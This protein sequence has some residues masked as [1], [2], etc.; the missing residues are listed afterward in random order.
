MWTIGYKA[1]GAF[2]G[3]ILASQGVITVMADY[4]NF[5]PGRVQH[6]LEDVDLALGWVHNNIHAYGGDPE[7]IHLMGTA[8]RDEQMTARA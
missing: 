7:N 1:W 4:R 5:P 8:K 3:R 2:F 6:M